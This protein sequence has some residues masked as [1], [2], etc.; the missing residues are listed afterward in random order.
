MEVLHAPA[1]PAV[2]ATGTVLSSVTGSRFAGGTAPYVRRA[3]AVMVPAPLQEEEHGP[4]RRSLVEGARRD[5][6][7]GP[8]RSGRGVAAGV[9]LYRDDAGKVY[10]I[11]IYSVYSRRSDLDGI[12]CERVR[13]KGAS[14]SS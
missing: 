11:E 13:V 6:R 14:A 8:G 2:N 5:G 9:V 12:D 3:R 4:Q 10:R 1:P 7:R